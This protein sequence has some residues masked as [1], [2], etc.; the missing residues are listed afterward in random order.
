MVSPEYESPGRKKHGGR[1]DGQ[2]CTGY[3]LRIC[4]NTTRLLC[5]KY[6]ES[7][8]FNIKNR[9]IQ[10]NAQEFPGSYYIV[11]YPIRYSSTWRAQSR[12]SFM[13]H[14]TSD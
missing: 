4:L 12:P 14:T 2:A 1:T 5:T 8:Y 3:Y 11:V 13:A 9:E 6:A 10:L 7:A